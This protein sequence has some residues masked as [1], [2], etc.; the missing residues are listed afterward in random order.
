VIKARM[1]TFYV[2]SDHIPRL[3]EAVAEVGKRM[4][5][6]PDFRGF[7]CLDHDS[8][9][10]EIMVLSLWDGDGM[11]ETQ[12]AYEKARDEIAARVDLGMR[13][14]EHSVLCLVPGA[15]H[16][17]RDVVPVLAS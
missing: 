8:V 5:W 14:S 17:L 2:E 13:T 3:I 1:L 7:V 11:E 16:D 6:R 4:S 12:A 15:L 10:H 9:R